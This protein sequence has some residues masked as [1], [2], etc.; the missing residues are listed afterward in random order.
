MTQCS[1]YLQQVSP[2]AWPQATDILQEGLAVGVRDGSVD[3]HA[4]LIYPVDELTVKRIQQLLLH[5]VLLPTE[6][7]S[8]LRDR[9]T[10]QAPLCQMQLDLLLWR[11]AIAPRCNE[12]GWSWRSPGWST[13]GQGADDCTAREL[14]HW[15]DQPRVFSS[16]LNSQPVASA[17]NQRAQVG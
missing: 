9:R 2:L 3:I 11:H 17:S 16:L 15:L 10:R 8:H 6:R 7:G 13:Q 14:W 12:W 5:H 1:P 4:H